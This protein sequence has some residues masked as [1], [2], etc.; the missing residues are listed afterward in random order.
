MNF[1]EDIY[2]LI[3]KYNQKSKTAKHYG[4]EE[5]LYTAEVHMIEIIGNY[6]KITTTKLSNVLGIT[7]GAVSQITRKLLDKNLIEKIPSK[8]RNNEVFISLTETGRTVYS[9]HQDM[10]K[11]M[12]D[13]IDGILNELPDEGKNALDKIIQV[14]DKS[15]D[16]I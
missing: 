15:L 13:K 6:E 3:N 2:R 12:L 11:D 5:L 14:I 7:K 10:H 9:Y 16:D 8:E 4:T 1:F